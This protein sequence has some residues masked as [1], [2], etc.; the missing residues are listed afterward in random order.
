MWMMLMRV[1]RI[2]FSGGFNRL[3]LRFPLFLA[4]SALFLSGALRAGEDVEIR[5]DFDRPDRLYSV[6]ETAAVT[7]AVMT[8]DDRP[9]ASG[10]LDVL[11]TNDGR[12]GRER[13]VFNLAEKNPVTVQATL[14]FP[15]F[16]R[17]EATASWKTSEGKPVRTLA[18]A[19]FDP[20]KITP[21]LPEPDDFGAFLE[22]GKKG[23][24]DIPIDV[25][26]ARLDDLS[27]DRRDIFAISF[28]TL[29][30]RRVYGYLSVP[31]TGSPPYPA[32]VHVPGGG[33]GMGPDLG[34]VDQ[35]FVALNFN[36]L[37]YAVPHDK[38]LRAEPFQKFT[39]ELGTD[40]WR[41]R[42]EDREAYYFRALF[43]GMDRAI[44]WLAE[45]DYVDAGRIG[46]VGASQG[47][48]AGLILC[49]MNR[50]LSIAVLGVPAFCD[51]T[52]VTIGRDPGWP[53]I[54][55][56][57]GGD[58]A[59][60]TAARYIDAVNFAR[61]VEADVFI[62][63]G[64]HDSACP[65]SSVYAAYNVIPSPNKVIMNEPDSGHQTGNNYLHALDRMKAAL[66]GSD[67]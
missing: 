58:P 34:N 29:D 35:G 57:S 26:T 52:A 22:A 15:G 2:G 62:T 32:I 60:L 67:R 19:G 1:K 9:A 48:G 42:R 55:D 6:G 8:A 39:E 33:S 5:V 10:T 56:E 38:T 31:K 28:A 11:L 17:F 53:R 36:V 41:Y 40:Y 50:H 12:D 61:R 20:E 27:N 25:Q 13:Y 18:A 51:Q 43:L 66:K 45:Q 16:L 21:S 44:D 24:R 59:I 54:A 65:P 64:F 47:G 46:Y 14:D 23:V 37:P 63:V 30:H 4:V 7:F 3:S 49:G